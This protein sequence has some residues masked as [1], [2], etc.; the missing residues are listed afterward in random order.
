M[1][2]LSE[3]AIG[4]IGRIAGVKGGWGIKHRLLLKGIREG[5]IVRMI[6]SCRGPI[7]VEVERNSIAL[8][9]GM[10]QK[11]LVKKG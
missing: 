11:I 9:R 3:L 6:S 5:S 8:G 4:E 1:C 10:A 2:L 7:V